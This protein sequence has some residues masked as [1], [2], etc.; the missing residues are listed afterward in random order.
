[1]PDGI[2]YDPWSWLVWGRELSHLNL[3]TAGAASSVKPLPMLVDA[4]LTIAGPAGPDLW[5]VVARAGTVM[6][7]LLAF[8]LGTRLGGR[9]AGLIATAGLLTSFQLIGYLTISGM[10]EPIGAAFALAACEAHIERRRW[11]ALLL[12][13]GASLVRIE[14]WGFM[15]V[16]AAVWI[17]PR[18]RHRVRSAAVVGGVLVVVLLAWLLPDVIG[19]GSA[20]R[21]A[22]RATFQSQ[23]GPLAARYPG[24]ATLKEATGILVIPMSVAFV[25]EVA[26][27]L[28]ALVRRHRVIASLGLAGVA[29]AW[30]VVEAVMAQLHLASGAPRYLLPAVGL[31]SVVAG[32]FW[33]RATRWLA[34]RVAAPSA[35]RLAGPGVGVV[36]VATS[37]AGLVNWSARVD[38]GW[39]NNGQLATL[40]RALPAAAA[41]AGGTGRILDCGRIATAPL[42]VPALSWVLRVPLGDVHDDPSVPGT[43]FSPA[44]RQPVIPARDAHAYRPVE[45]GGATPPWQVLTTCP[46]EG[47]VP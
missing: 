26:I 19:S 29:V 5:L 23:G 30:V 2:G 37:A 9:A 14:V 24:L 44:P 46:L 18:S 17:L 39:Q 40:T 12:L 38:G 35:K 1:M 3:V 33:V 28:V 47:S 20:L 27:G 22:S 16:Y 10:S 34:A 21:S 41:G 7:L 43:V 25:I 13:F 11:T 42:Q 6:A 45:S 32:A 8:R 4:V 36:L 15:V 31:A